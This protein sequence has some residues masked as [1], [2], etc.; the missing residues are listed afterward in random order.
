MTYAAA[1]E[2]I[3]IPVSFGLSLLGM[4][5]VFIVLIFLMVIIYI[6]TALIRKTTAKPAMAEGNADLAEAFEITGEQSQDALIP[7]DSLQ[8]EPS[9][10]PALQTEPEAVEPSAAAEPEEPSVSDV[11]T[12]EVITVKKYRVV[13]NGAEYEVD[14]ETGEIVPGLAAPAP[15]SE[16]SEEPAVSDGAEIEIYTEKKYRVVVNGMEY[17]VGSETG[18][19]APGPAT[20]AIKPPGDLVQTPAVAAASPAGEVIVAKKY[21]VVVNGAEY[22][23]DAESGE[24]AAIAE[25]G[26]EQ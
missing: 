12:V 13:V 9:S 5:I 11:L 25:S 14:S 16:A 6:M 18:E 15:E 22:E 3:T 21:R 1:M 8:V 20:P 7:A 17:V 23:V 4:V 2:N 10:S 19:I 26:K 24:T